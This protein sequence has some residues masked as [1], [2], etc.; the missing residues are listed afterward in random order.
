[1]TVEKIDQDSRLDPLFHALNSQPA[2]SACCE[3]E[4]LAQCCEPAAKEACCGS[5]G[6]YCR[7]V[8][9]VGGGG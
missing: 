9:L 5:S 2:S 8:P 4:T 7:E 3:P 6:S 1:M